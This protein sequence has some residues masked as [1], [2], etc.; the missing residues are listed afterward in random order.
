MA[1]LMTSAS[2]ILNPDMPDDQT[3]YTLVRDL[4]MPSERGQLRCF[5]MRLVGIKDLR[6]GLALVWCDR[7]DINEC[8]NSLVT[9]RFNHSSCVSV[10]G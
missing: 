4:L 10:A 7:C 9:Y 6:D 1:R 5:G 2:A 8:Q 3:T